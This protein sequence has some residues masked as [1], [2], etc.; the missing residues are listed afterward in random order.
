MVDQVPVRPISGFPEW[1]PE[2]RIAEQRLIGAIREQ[3]ELFGFAPIE[4]P[5]AERMEVLL[6]KGGITRQ[7][8]TLG[9]AAEDDARDDAQLG[10]HFDLTV[11]LARYIAQHGDALTFPFRRYQIQKVW[12]G[13]RA[14]RG[15]FREFLQCDADIVGSG[16]LDLI[17]DA[18][19]VCL[20]SA[21]FARMGVG[22]A[23]VRVSNRKILQALCDAA[24]LTAAHAA[25]ALRAVDKGDVAAQIVPPA[26]TELVALDDLD[27]AA[28]VLKRAGAALDGIEE[29]RAVIDGALQLGMP[30]GQLVPDL[31][32]ARGL[33]YYTGTVYETF[34]S[35]RES[36]G[37]VC[38]GGRYDDLATYFTKRVHPGVGI[39]IGLTRLLDLL[40]A[41]GRVEAGPATPAR[42]LVTMLDRERYFPR[43]LAL[44]RELR[45][46]GIA[47]DLYLQPDGLR[48]QLAYAA[49]KGFV[50]AVIAGGREFDEGVVSVRDLRTRDQRQV[51]IDQLVSAVSADPPT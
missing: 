25:E 35:G 1:L 24:G 3:Y 29:L 10:L 14:Q 42:V 40:V 37:S 30:P 49:A 44:A 2:L 38:S 8:Y 32:I 47:T 5:A 11:P 46:G 16:S 19:M 45:S 20:I 7:I 17:H 50:Y 21:V 36:W 13:E 22:D 34:L 48:D 15:R 4:T 6:A 9:R 39:S 31:S 51:P 23:V 18:E 41:D 27:A 26:I 28:A 43:Y 33:D 12:R